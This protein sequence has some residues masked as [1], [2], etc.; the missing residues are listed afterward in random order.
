M[1]RSPEQILWTLDSQVDV[2][3]GQRAPKPVFDFPGQVEI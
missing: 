2:T 3:P 1:A